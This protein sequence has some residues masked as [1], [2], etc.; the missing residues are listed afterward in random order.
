MGEKKDW[1]AV[2]QRI[3][4]LLARFKEEKLTTDW[5]KKDLLELQYAFASLVSEIVQYVEETERKLV[6][7]VELIDLWKEDK[8]YLPLTKEL[9]AQDHYR[10]YKQLWEELHDLLTVRQHADDLYFRVS[11]TAMQL[12]F[13]IHVMHE[14]NIIETPKKG[15]LFRFIS[16]HIGTLQQEE[17]SYE[18]LRKKFH[19]TDRNTI[20]KVRR[21]L[22]DLVNLINNRHL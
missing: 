15:N 11:I 18:S 4:R 7:R 21:L 2:L 17:L 14:A 3:G 5:E 1:S 8:P 9:F 10:F 16:R 19:A 6:S 20:L 12:L 22:M 13:L